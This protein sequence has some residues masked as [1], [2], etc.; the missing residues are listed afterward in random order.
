MGKDKLK[1]FAELKTFERVFE[2]AVLDLLEND[3]PL[4]GK[5][6]QLFANQQPIVLELGCGKCEYTLALAKQY[7]NANF[8]GIDIKGARMW[9][10]AKTA[11]QTQLKNVAF[12]RTRIEFIH[13]LFAANEISEIWI[14]FPDPQPKKVQNRLTASAFL[15]RYQKILK[16]NG[17]I[18]L[19]TDSQ[20]LYQY[21]QALIEHNKLPILENIAHVHASP[22]VKEI[23][24]VKTFYEQRFIK[25]G[26]SITYLS[27]RLPNTQL[28]AEPIFDDSAFTVES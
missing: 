1:R 18:H 2:P 12:L 10:G 6:Q 8:V 4:K 23:L 7:P 20:L 15:T 11:Q 16:N 13:R 19:K 9:R 24:K 21:T 27:F 5:W 25:D 26:K 22:N 3:S 14:T 28:L 17:L